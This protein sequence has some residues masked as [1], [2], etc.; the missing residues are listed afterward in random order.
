MHRRS[1]VLLARVFSK[2]RNASRVQ[3]ISLPVGLIQVL[4][5]SGFVKK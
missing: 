5:S 4:A 1:K 2:S 3:P